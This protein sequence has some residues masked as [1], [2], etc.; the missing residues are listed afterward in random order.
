MTLHF[1]RSTEKNKRQQ[2]RNSMPDAEVILWSRLKGRQLLEG[3]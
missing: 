2:L 3:I 1:N